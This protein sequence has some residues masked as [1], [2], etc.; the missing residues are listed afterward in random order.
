MHAVMRGEVKGKAGAQS[1]CAKTNGGKML[2]DSIQGAVMKC[3]GSRGTHELI[4]VQRRLTL[5]CGTQNQL[6]VT[7]RAHESRRSR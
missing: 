5:H 4:E 1:M 6:F 3:A 2:S 7:A